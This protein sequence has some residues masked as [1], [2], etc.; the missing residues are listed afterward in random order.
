VFLSGVAVP[1][2]GFKTKPVGRTE[3]DRD[4]CAHQEDSQM[5]DAL[6]ILKRTLM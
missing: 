5:R 4:S 2:H 3:C 1:N 6:G